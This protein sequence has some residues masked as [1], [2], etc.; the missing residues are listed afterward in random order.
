MKLQLDS[1]IPEGY[2]YIYK[3]DVF[4]RNNLYYKFRSSCKCCGN[5]YF[6]RLNYPTN[7]CSK[8]CA[9]KD[10]DV[11][12][13]ISFSLT[14]H[15]RSSSEVEKIRANKSKG[16]VVARN[17]PLYSTYAGQVSLLE[18]MRNNNGVL[19]VKCSLCGKWF[20]PKRT[21]VEARAQY[22]KGNIDRESRLYCS[23]ICKLNCPIFNKHK[24]PK[25]SNPKKKRYS[26]YYNS[27]LL[28]TWSRTILERSKYICEYC[29][30]AASVA[31]HIVPKKV[32]PFKALD[33]DNGIACCVECHYSKAHKD[34]CSTINL[35]K[36]E[37]K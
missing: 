10:I 17:I 28:N 25:G 15:K 32:D 7:F 23:D 9:S 31:H 37:C 27:N 5:S 6:M 20:T 33:I 3:R 13:K 35:A 36:I 24:Y 1:D 8:A 34:E 30:G 11:R 21:A 4:R 29:G 14:G 18:D 19:E 12:S 2:T 22:I 26:N 16:G